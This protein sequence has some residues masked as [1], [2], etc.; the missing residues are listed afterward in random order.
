MLNSCIYR[1]GKK[2]SISVDEEFTVLDVKLRLYEMTSV[3][4]ERQKIIGL[5]KG[6][7]PE[8]SVRLQD[9]LLNVGGKDIMLLGTPE[10]AIFKDPQFIASLPDVLDD[11]DDYQASTDGHLNYPSLKDTPEVQDKLKRYTAKTD[12][13]LL[14]PLDTGKK[15]L[16]LD[17]DYT[18][19]DHKSTANNVTELIRPGMH[20]FL[21]AVSPFFNIAIW[22][23]TSRQRLHTKLDALGILRHDEYKLSFYLDSMSMFTVISTKSGQAW[24]HQVKALDIVWTNLG[25]SWGAHNTIHVDDLNRNFALNPKNGLKIA[26]FKH[27]NTNDLELV[28]LALYLRDMAAEPDLSQV[29]HSKWRK[30]RDRSL[31]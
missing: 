28:H 24:Q 26:P 29:D 5:V 8:D 16:I 10:N 6:K 14:H 21:T 7:L 30:H 4:P 18:L 12:I 15:L 9:V 3:L 11:F 17:L 13:D 27:K 25:P 2:F 19:F 22:S 31:M 23:Q 20:D 1:S